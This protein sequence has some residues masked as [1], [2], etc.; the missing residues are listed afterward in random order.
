MP[1]DKHYH[2]GPV[3]ISMKFKNRFALLL[4]SIFSVYF[5]CPVLCPVL[6]GVDYGIFAS[7]QTENHSTC[8]HV[9]PA[10]NRDKLHEIS[11][12]RARH[13]AEASH[14]DHADSHHQLSLISPPSVEETSHSTCCP[15]GQQVPA[16][17][18]GQ[19]HSD[20]NCC[21]DRSALL[22][23]SELRP[24]PKTSQ[25]HFLFIALIPTPCPADPSNTFSRLRFPTFS[26]SD[27]PPTYQIY[28]RA[29]PF[30]L[31]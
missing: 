5:L 29:P 4:L 12:N 11:H 22:G 16:Q 6:R 27:S 2:I 15:S 31:A 13:H 19:E 24:A 10:S 30:S 3:P 21:I 14:G 17:Q 28:A 20:D 7:R 25:Q 18:K 23:T 26:P 8:H 1:S 9:Q